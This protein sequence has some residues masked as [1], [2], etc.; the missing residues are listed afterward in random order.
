MKKRNKGLS[1]VE[2]IIAIAIIAVFSGVAVYS[3]SNIRNYRARECSRKITSNIAEVKV[4]SLG[5][6]KSNGDIVW[7]LYKENGKFYV[8]Y[9]A[10]CA[11]TPEVQKT[12][13]ISKGKMN[14]FVEDAGG[15]RTEVA[16][17]QS[18]K[19]CF[20]RATGAMY[21]CG[22]AL[23]STKGTPSSGEYDAELTTYSALR[24]III[25]A[26]GKEYITEFVPTTGKING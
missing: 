10:G 8:R 15:T 17:N 18:V 5:K 19:V 14:C 11:G 25:T 26:G 16:D 13:K 12:T 9:L 22:G 4:T 3:A 21:T 2:L 6:A 20:N 7:E 1:L 23:V 24:K